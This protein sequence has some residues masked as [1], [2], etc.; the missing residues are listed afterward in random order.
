VTSQF[1]ETPDFLELPPEA[2]LWSVGWLK[3]AEAMSTNP[4]GKP[5]V[6]QLF[7][8]VLEAG[9]VP[10]QEDRG[11]QI[12][13]ESFAIFLNGVVVYSENLSFV[14]RL[15]FSYLTLYQAHFSD[16]MQSRIIG[17]LELM[18]RPFF[19]TQE[20]NNAASGKLP[21][22]RQNQSPNDSLACPTPSRRPPAAPRSPVPAAPDFLA[23]LAA[24]A[25]STAR[26]EAVGRA[27][28]GS[29]V[30]GAER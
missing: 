4:D 2:R 24:S 5:L 10:V 17:G 18:A 26:P 11:N 23:A 3:V 25:V 30:A 28:G 27:A 12:G 22:L 20:E 9:D 19:R 7:Q 15:A 1:T 21:P 14:Q 6:I 29:E 16:E 8:R 13:L